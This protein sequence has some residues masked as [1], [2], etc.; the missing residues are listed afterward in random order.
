MHYSGENNYLFINGTEITK[1]KA[2]Y[3]EITSYPLCLGN[4]SKDW[5][6]NNMKITGLQGCIYEFSFDYDK[7]VCGKGFICNSYECD[8][9]FDV[10]E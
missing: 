6:M 5:F 3:S 8:K 9:S 2:K 10:G 7:G 4:M 1:F